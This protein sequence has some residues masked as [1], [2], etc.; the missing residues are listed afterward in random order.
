M[1]DGAHSQEVEDFH[2]Q[3][4]DLVPIDATPVKSGETLAA[5]A[6]NSEA[7]LFQHWENKTPLPLSIGYLVVA[8]PTIFAERDATWTRTSRPSSSLSICSMSCV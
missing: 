8:T 3:F 2:K 7:C 5:L 6:G 1:L 4:P